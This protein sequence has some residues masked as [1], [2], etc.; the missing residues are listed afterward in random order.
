MMT[1]VWALLGTLVCVIAYGVLLFCQA[2]S[3]IGTAPKQEM[4]LCAKH[5]ALPAKACIDINTNEMEYQ[6]E[7]GETTTRSVLY[8]PICYEDQ[9]KDAEKFYK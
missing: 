1:L 3:H 8:C 7:T 2:K 9:I 4:F 5:G 6:L